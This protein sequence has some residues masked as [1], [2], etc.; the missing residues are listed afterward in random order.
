M[1]LLPNRNILDG[2]KVPATTTSDM[3]TALGSLRDYLADILGT[4][5][6]LGL[7]SAP[8]VQGL[9]GTPNTAAPLTKYDLS[10]NSVVLRNIGGNTVARYVTGTITNDLGLAGSTANGR[11]QAA[12]FA[13]NS[14]VYLY[15]VWNGTALATVSSLALPTVGPTLPTGYTHWAF[16]TA[17]RWNASSNIIP[18]RTMGSSTWY[19]LA[20]AGV[21]RVLAA[22]VSTTMT[23]VACSGF[24]PPIAV[25][26]TFS[27]LLSLNNAAVANFRL[28]VRPTGSSITKLRAVVVSMQVAS[29][30]VTAQNTF[31]LPLGTSTQIDYLLD[32]VPSVGGAYIDV[33]GF[34]IPN[35]DA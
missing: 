23:A 27:F 3:K 26:G 19:E 16:A 33:T 10:A 8:R 21:N 1:A 24:I 9:V 29:T 32:V 35:G 4:D 13:V 20:D 22:G 12:V 6:S 17:V 11:D 7:G 18:M 15:Y 2:T 5:S 14:W 25:L 28:D 31:S 34:T 30:L